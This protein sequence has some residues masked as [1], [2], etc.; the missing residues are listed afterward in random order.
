[1]PWIICPL[2]PPPTEK[3]FIHITLP[4]CSPYNNCQHFTSHLKCSPW[5]ALPIF[6]TYCVSSPVSN[7]SLTLQEAAI[8][9]SYSVF[10][11]RHPSLSLFPT[12]INYKYDCS[13]LQVRP[14]THTQL[15]YFSLPLPYSSN[16]TMNLIKPKSLS[17][18]YQSWEV[19][20]NWRK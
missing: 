20:H 18:L 5:L 10:T 17:T 19:E 8:Y 14:R 6:S 3:P 13:S 4:Q 11:T 15:S 16:K 12:A 2:T 7:S 9:R 1:M